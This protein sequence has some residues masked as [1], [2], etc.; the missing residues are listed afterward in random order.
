MSSSYRTTR[1]IGFFD[2][3]DELYWNA[4][5]TG[6]TFPIDVAEARITLPEPVPFPQSAF[7][8]GPQGAS[9]QDAAIVEQRPGH[10]VFRTTQPLPAAQRPHGRRRLAEGRGGRADRGRSRRRDGCEDNPC[11]SRSRRSAAAAGA[12]LLSSLRGC[13][14]GRDP[15]RGTII[16]LFAPP[17][18]MSAGGG[19]LR[20]GTWASTTTCFTA[21]IIDLGVNG[22]LKLIERK[23]DMTLVPHKSGGKPLDAA[24]AG[25]R[26]RRCSRS[27]RTRGARQDR[28]TRLLGSA[29]DG[30]ARRR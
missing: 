19:A 16:P 30:A 1:Q 5:G 12:R 23:G 2:D 17:D 20:R 4:T 11:R 26:A 7:Y 24:G 29:H 25:G 9:G 18:G 6:W 8:T 21:A 27:G 28:N 22:H 3:Y 13:M 15:P 14:V 10:I